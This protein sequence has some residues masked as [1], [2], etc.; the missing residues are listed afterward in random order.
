MNS[1]KT[2]VHATVL[3]SL[4]SL[5]AFGGGLTASSSGALAGD[6]FSLEA[7]GAG[8]I[9]FLSEQEMSDTKGELAFLVA[10]IVGIDL[11]LIGTFWGVYV[12]NAG[13]G[14]CL[15]CSLADLRR[16]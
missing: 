13:G 14:S 3:A 15:N 1:F 12:P 2:L 16:H 10:A 11:A 8:E 4:V 6:A 9:D 5:P 7:D